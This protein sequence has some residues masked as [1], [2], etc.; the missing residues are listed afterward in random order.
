MFTDQLPEKAYIRSFVSL[1]FHLQQKHRYVHINVSV[2]HKC[3]HID[4]YVIDE[5]LTN[6]TLNEHILD[7]WSKNTF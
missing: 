2:V 1:I 6:K 7:I 3:E 5:N 4:A